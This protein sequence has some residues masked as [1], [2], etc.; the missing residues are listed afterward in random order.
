[1][2]TS[3]QDCAICLFFE[4]KN[5]FS[6]P[7]DAKLGFVHACVYESNAALCISSEDATRHCCCT[8]QS[9]REVFAAKPQRVTFHGRMKN[10]M[11]RM[12]LHFSSVASMKLCLFKCCYD[13]VGGLG[14]GNIE[15][16]LVTS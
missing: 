6:R 5:G 1:M 10:V 4:N 2:L 16:L 12:H 11:H 3:I 15:M 13:H 8:F 14:A 7:T 9:A